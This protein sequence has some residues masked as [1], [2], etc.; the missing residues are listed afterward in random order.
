MLIGSVH[1]VGDRCVFHDDF[2]RRP[3]EETYRSYF[4]EVLAM[5]RCGGFD[6]L[7]HLDVVAR[8][9]FEAYGGYEPLRYETMIRPILKECIEKGI[10]LDVNGAC[11]S[12]PL[13]RLTPGKEILAWYAELGGMN[14]IASSDA[15]KPSEVGRNLEK[16]Y[17]AIR[18]SGVKH[19]V[20]FTR[21]ILSR[22]EV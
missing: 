17:E 7:G 8:K 15:H 20:C 21:R 5:A 9:G 19:I 1:W 3:E 6:V 13:G 12:R 2:F 10:A 18:S 16:V 11:A 14:L 4:E 22:M